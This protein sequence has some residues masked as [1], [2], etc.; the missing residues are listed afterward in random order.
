MSF[1]SFLES[2]TEWLD[3][4]AA[5]RMLRLIAFTALCLITVILGVCVAILAFL[6]VDSEEFNE[7]MTKLE[8]A[9][10][11]VP[12]NVLERVKAEGY[13]TERA[14]LKRIARLEAGLD[15]ALDEVPPRVH[16]WIRAQGYLTER[17]FLHHIQGSPPPKVPA[18][19]Q[20][21]PPPMP[22]PAILPQLPLPF[23]NAKLAPR[24]SPDED[25]QLS[26]DSEGVRL[27]P[28]HEIAL[29][30][31]VKAFTPCAE[32]RP[33]QLVVVGYASTRQFVD[34]DGRPLPNSDALNL[35]AANLR[36][37]G[38][39][40]Y[41]GSSAQGFEIIHKPWKS[42]EAMRRPFVDR[43]EALQGTEQEAL[44][45]SV[46]VQVHDAGGCQ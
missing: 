4:L 20:A 14:F 13:L 22:S 17:V 33:V 11:A 36:A 35:Q 45:R 28:A 5:L 12:S 41:L 42:F 37:Q 1:K 16:E 2:L 26:P 24:Q 21:D 29:D 27:A 40:N 6:P 30:T 3:A 38:V 39:A 9:V 18:R 46:V 15:D 10:D 8:E 32:V 19:R 23:E 44:N 34:Q 43:S 31:F 7:R 25:W